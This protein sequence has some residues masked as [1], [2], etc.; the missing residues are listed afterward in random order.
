MA[1]RLLT[2]IKRFIGESIDDKPTDCQ[3]GSTFLELDTGDMYVFSV[4]DTKWHLKEEANIAL[5]LEFA[6][7][8]DAIFEELKKVNENLF[9]VIEALGG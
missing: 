1:V 7:R 4:A 2:T 6:K 8:S 5:R 9:L 3:N